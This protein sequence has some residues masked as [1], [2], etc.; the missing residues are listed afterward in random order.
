MPRFDRNLRS[1]QGVLRPVLV[2][3]PGPEL[4]RLTPANAAGLRFDGGLWVK[5]AR[6]DHGAFVHL[7]PTQGGAGA[8]DVAAVLRQRGR[9]DQAAIGPTTAAAWQTMRVPEG[10]IDPETTAACD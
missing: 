4:A 1:V 3:R 7:L 9:A 6:I 8:T 2:H 5:Q 10:S